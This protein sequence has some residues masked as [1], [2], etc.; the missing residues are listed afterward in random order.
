MN[1]TERR[2]RATHTQ[3]VSDMPS[4]TVGDSESRHNC[5]VFSVMP[6]SQ[7]TALKVKTNSEDWTMRLSQRHQLPSTRILSCWRQCVTAC[8][9]ISTSILN[10]DDQYKKHLPSYIQLIM[11]CPRDWSREIALRPSVNSGGTGTDYKILTK[12][13]A[14]LGLQNSIPTVLHQFTNHFKAVIVLRCLLMIATYIV[15]YITTSP[16]Y[17]TVRAE[18]QLWLVIDWLNSHVLHWF[19]LNLLSLTRECGVTIFSVASL[20][21]S[22]CPVPDVYTTTTTTTTTTTL[23]S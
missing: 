21:V 9:R 12:Y 7:C 19:I 14:R 10:S 17:T 5:E 13:T 22:A 16:T 15:P 23:F 2:P 20:C 11:T 3:P 6:S 4:Y 8:G 1:T 18:S